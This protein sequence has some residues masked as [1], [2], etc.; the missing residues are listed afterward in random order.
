MKD[1]NRKP[2]EDRALTA[3]RSRRR[4]IL[5]ALAVVVL[6]ASVFG[7]QYGLIPFG[8]LLAFSADADEEKARRS[9]IVSRRNLGLAVVTAAVFIWFWLWQVISEWPRSCW[10][11]AR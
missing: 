5:I 10:S 8:L 3:P 9:V 11:E 4:L 7:G 2:T 1:S 6:V